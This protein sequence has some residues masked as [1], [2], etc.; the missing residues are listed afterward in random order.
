MQKYATKP[1]IRIV[2]YNSIEQP[3]DV[4]AV[5]TQLAQFLTEHPY[6]KVLFRPLKNGIITLTLIYSEMGP[7]AARKV[8]IS[9]ALLS[10][11][12]YCHLYVT[13]LAARLLN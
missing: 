5:L 8:R 12:E 6:Y 3:N 1:D 4:T 11:Q 10:E 7:F 9:L 2:H 13:L